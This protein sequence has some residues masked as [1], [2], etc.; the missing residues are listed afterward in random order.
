MPKRKSP[1]EIT[2]LK[3]MKLRSGTD[4]QHNCQENC[5]KIID[6]G[7][8]MKTTIDNGGGMKTTIGSWKVLFGPSV[9]QEEWNKNQVESKLT[10]K[11][12][13]EYRNPTSLESKADRE[14][15]EQKKPCTEAPEPNKPHTY[16]F[17]PWPQEFQ[18]KKACTESFDKPKKQPLS[19]GL[20][21]KSPPGPLSQGSGEKSPPGPLSQGKSLAPSG[22]SQD[23]SEGK[24]AD[25]GDSGAPTFKL[26]KSP[27]VNILTACVFVMA[28]VFFALSTDGNDST[29]MEDVS[30]C[31]TQ[32]STL[33]EDVTEMTNII[34]QEVD[35]Y[36]NLSPAKRRLLIRKLKKKGITQLTKAAKYVAKWVAEHFKKQKAKKESAKVKEATKLE[37]EKQAKKTLAGLPIVP[38]RLFSDLRNVATSRL[39]KRLL[40]EQQRPSRTRKRMPSKLAMRSKR[41]SKHAKTRA[42]KSKRFSKNAKTI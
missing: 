10:K 8:G 32:C 6:N 3:R 29:F 14:A 19:Q 4:E 23:D 35:K 9:S 11:E 16:T 28:F 37:K 1:A 31:A 30:S 7:G 17:T 5:H 26:P 18:Q 41:V 27:C 36:I 20:G 38:K 15:R 21:E 34:K 2:T 39:P 40:K 24:S 22:T 33:M 42:M 12:D 13:L 25:S